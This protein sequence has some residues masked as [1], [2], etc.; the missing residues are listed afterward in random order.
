MLAHSW[1]FRGEGSTPSPGNPI[2]KY[3]SLYLETICDFHHRML[4]L[5]LKKFVLTHV[6]WYNNG[7]YF[8]HIN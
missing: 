4:N 8:S 5:H 1:G 6:L 2:K 7:K 3:S